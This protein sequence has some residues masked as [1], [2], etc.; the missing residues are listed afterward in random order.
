MD[1]VKN[2]IIIIV[3]SLLVAAASLAIAAYWQRRMSSLLDKT[4]IDNAA[5]FVTTWTIAFIVTAVAG[6]WTTF[7]LY[8]HWKQRDSYDDDG[9]LLE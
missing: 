1:D 3:V 7:R 4:Q 9:Y 6:V 2:R 8:L 5:Y